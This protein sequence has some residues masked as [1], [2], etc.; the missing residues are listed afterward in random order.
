MLESF[1]TAFNQLGVNSLVNHQSVMAEIDAYFY[2][3]FALFR[4]AKPTETDNMETESTLH[5]H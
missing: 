3:H 1:A 2:N 5:D 4:L